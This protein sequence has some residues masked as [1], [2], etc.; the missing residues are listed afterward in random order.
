MVTNTFI[1][2]TV[3][4]PKAVVEAVGLGA[5]F[6]N[7]AVLAETGPL[8]AVAIVTTV[9]QA[10]F[11]AA[12]VPGETFEALALTIHAAPLILAVIGALWLC[13]VEAL[14]S[15]FTGAAAAIRA[16]VSTPVTVRLCGQLTC[17][18]AEQQRR[19]HKQPSKCK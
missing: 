3:P 2:H 13:A 14:P 7:E 11:D 16:P 8:H 5:V 15:R 17:W 19:V 9:H 12:I 4:T 1:L 18:R 10:D 6:T